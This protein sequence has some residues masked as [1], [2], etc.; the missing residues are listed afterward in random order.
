MLKKRI[1]NNSKKYRGKPCINALMIEIFANLAFFKLN[2]SLKNF[3]IV[4]FLSIYN[5]QCILENTE[6]FFPYKYCLIDPN[7]VNLSLQAKMYKKEINNNKQVT[8]RVS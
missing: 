8:V 1:A 3:Q 6:F 7:A 4:K 5:F 2:F